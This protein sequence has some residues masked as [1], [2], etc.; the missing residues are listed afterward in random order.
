MKLATLRSGRRDGRLIVVRRD[1]SWAV[2]ASDISPTLQAALDEWST[3]APALQEAFAKQLVSVKP[4]AS[5]DESKTW[6]KGEL[7]AWRKITTEVKIIR[8]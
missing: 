4:N 8:P 3:K 1:L 5:L 6:L 2:E 7:D